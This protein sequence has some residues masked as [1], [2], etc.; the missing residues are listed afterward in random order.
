MTYDILES[1]FGSI[2]IAVHETDIRLINFQCGAGSIRIPTDWQNEVNSGLILEAKRQLQAY[3]AGKLKHF[4]LPLN[5]IGTLFQKKVWNE[6]SKIPYGETVSYRDIAFAMRKPGACRAV[7]LAN[8]RNPIQ[9][10]VPCHRVIGSDG[11]LTG[12]AAG[13]EIKRSLLELES[14]NSTR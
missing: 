7:G 4:E 13:L 3:F 14:K 2:I 10:V 1:D 8:R 11:K 12:Y 5:P 9:I 6:L